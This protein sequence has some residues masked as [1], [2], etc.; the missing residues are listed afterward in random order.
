MTV[1]I[2]AGL[3]SLHPD[4]MLRSSIVGVFQEYTNITSLLNRYSNLIWQEAQKY[5][6][7]TLP[8]YTYFKFEGNE[9]W[10]HFHVQKLF[11]LPPPPLLSDILQLQEY[12]LYH[13]PS[14]HLSLHIP[15][16]SGVWP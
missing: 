10:H 2:A 5:T 12:E 8:Y 3:E 13:P 14:P 4:N 6:D 9:I 16:A 1:G 7:K 11:I 15:G